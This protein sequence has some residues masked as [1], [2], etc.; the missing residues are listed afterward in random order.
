MCLN[1]IFADTLQNS[2]AWI[3]RRVWGE[4]QAL[5][6]CTAVTAGAAGGEVISPNYL[7]NSPKVSKKGHCLYCLWHMLRLGFFIFFFICSNLSQGFVGSSAWNHSDQ[8]WLGAAGALH[9]WG[10][11]LRPRKGEDNER[12]GTEGDDGSP[13]P[14]ACREGHHHQLGV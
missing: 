1:V 7:K 9:C 14:G 6:R 8:S 13:S 10:A 3:K 5:Q 11:V 12:A 4:K 2:G